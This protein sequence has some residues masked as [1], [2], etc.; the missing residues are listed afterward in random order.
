MLPFEDVSIPVILSRTRPVSGSYSQF[1]DNPQA[2]GE[3]LDGKLA[4]R[5]A[6]TQPIIALDMT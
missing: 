2:R 4:M 6:S 1:R 3:S 5:V